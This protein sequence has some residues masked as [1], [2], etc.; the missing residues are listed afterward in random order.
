RARG[1]SPSAAAT[2]G[3]TIAD[4]YTYLPSSVKRFPAPADL[5]GEL[6]R[7]GLEEISYVLL[8]GGIVAIHAG[9]VAAGGAG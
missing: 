7:A 3:V 4:A 1:P 9:T 2:G 6:A 5:A 8:A